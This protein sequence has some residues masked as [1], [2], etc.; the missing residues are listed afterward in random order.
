MEDLLSGGTISYA[1]NMDHMRVRHLDGT[2]LIM[3]SEALS[4]SR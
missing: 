1:V 4:S 3:M 2:V